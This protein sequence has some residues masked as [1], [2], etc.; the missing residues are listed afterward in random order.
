MEVNSNEGR[1]ID[2]KCAFFQA[3]FQTIVTFFVR[4]HLNLNTLLIVF[5][6]YSFTVRS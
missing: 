6:K 1:L 3:I 4:L 2:E 5:L